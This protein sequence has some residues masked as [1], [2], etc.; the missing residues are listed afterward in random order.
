MTQ[1]RHATT[2]AATLYLQE[3]LDNLENPSR[4][5][6][7]AFRHQISEAGRHLLLVLTTLADQTKLEILEESFQTFYEFRRQRFGFPTK[8][9]DWTDALRELDGNFIKTERVGHDIVVSFHNPSIRD[10]MERFLEKS[11]ADTLDLLRGAR[12]YEQYVSLWSGMREHRYRAIE[13]AGAEFVTK[14]T[15]NLWSP[16]ARTI[17]EV[18]NGEAVG[19]V[20]WSPSEER[21]SAF[22]VPEVDHVHP[23][24]AA[25]YTDALLTSLAER[26]AGGHGDRGDLIRFLELLAARGILPD[27]KV[28]VAGRDYL[29]T[30]PE[31]ID[32]FRAA[33]KFC[34]AYPESVSQDDRDSLKTQF[35]DFASD[36]A[37]KWNSDDDPD[38]LREVASHLETLG[39][40]FGVNT[41]DETQGLLERAEEIETER[42]ERQRDHDADDDDGAPWTGDTVIDDVEQMF[43]GLQ[44]DLKD[45]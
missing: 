21:R 36:Y 28:F 24:T 31:T 6:E 44:S 9:G 10:F 29:L 14:L 43:G 26:W 25:K 2:V 30:R 5:W 42:A 16:S 13:R 35:M 19:V 20:P 45:V 11:D 8:P 7:H 4:I 32:D 40:T 33:A 27:H 38:W 1:A 34:D 3:F 41:D 12:F 18:R 37:S 23:K 22:Y 39:E 17:R 15:A